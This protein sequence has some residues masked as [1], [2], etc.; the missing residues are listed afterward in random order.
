VTAGIVSAKGRSNVGLA[1]YEDFIQTDA[2]INPGNSGGP[3]LNLRGEIVGINT[4]IASQTGGYQGVS[5]AVP[6]RMAQDVMLQLIQTGKVTRGWLG[7]M[8]QNLDETLGL[9]RLRTHGKRRGGALSGDQGAGNE[10]RQENSDDRHGRAT[11]I[12]RRGPEDGAGSLRGGIRAAGSAESCS[13]RFAPSGRLAPCR[14]SR[15]ARSKAGCRRR[16][17]ASLLPLAFA[18]PL[19]PYPIASLKNRSQFPPSSFSTCAVVYPR[20]ASPRVMLRKRSGGSSSAIQGGQRT[21]Y[22][23]GNVFNRGRYQRS[24][25]CVASI[26]RME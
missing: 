13:K 12:C 26:P 14:L 10:T 25:V 15:Q 9:A 6:S 21:R 1:D 18:L 20:F 3:M 7:V 11:S 19:S 23:G 8:I 17:Q 2:A 24:R 16:S 22:S 4:A 5:F